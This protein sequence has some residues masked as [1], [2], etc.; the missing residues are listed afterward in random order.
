[1]VENHFDKNVLELV[2]LP[3]E[4]FD[5]PFQNPIINSYWLEN[6]ND[7]PSTARSSLRYLAAQSRI[8]TW[9]CRFSSGKFIS[10]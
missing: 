6:K 7:L 3:R 9:C 2:A 10:T 4:T 8:A 1:M 5:Y